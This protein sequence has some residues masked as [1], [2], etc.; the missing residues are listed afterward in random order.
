ML[1]GEL[2][3]GMEGGLGMVCGVFPGW[4]SPQPLLPQIPHSWGQGEPGPRAPHSGEHQSR[5]HRR[6]SDCLWPRG[7][8][9]QLNLI[10]GITSQIPGLAGVP[11]AGH[12]GFTSGSAPGSGDLLH[13]GF[14]CHS[15]AAP[16]ALWGLGGAEGPCPM[17]LSLLTSQQV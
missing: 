2:A 9:I 4:G 5:E 13:L 6:L 17:S 14:I 1:V 15:A 11:L 7:A 12:G 10:W 16:A 8:K 3:V